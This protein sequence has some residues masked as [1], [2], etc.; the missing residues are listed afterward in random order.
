ML[1]QNRLDSLLKIAEYTHRSEVL[2]MKDPM[3]F[4]RTRR[5]YLHEAIEVRPE[6]VR[7]Q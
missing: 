7:L 2:V 4:T 3:I 5:A 1:S 6:E